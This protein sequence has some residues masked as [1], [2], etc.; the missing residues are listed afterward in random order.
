[1][2]VVKSLVHELARRF[3]GPNS[4]SFTVAWKVVRH[5]RQLL[6]LAPDAAPPD[7]FRIYLADVER[8][9]LELE[10]LL[11]ERAFARSSFFAKLH[12]QSA[13]GGRSVES[14]LSTT[15]RDLAELYIGLVVSGLPFSTG[16]E[17]AMLEEMRRALRDAVSDVVDPLLLDLSDPAVPRGTFVALD[18]CCPNSDRLFERYMTHATL[19]FA[20][21]PCEPFTR[22]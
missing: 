20:S 19:A 2:R 6:D 18:A 4:G 21:Y 8:D 16:D 7:Y 12:A 13:L 3:P 22:R 14:M 9:R 11:A 17:A 15:V 1:M 10:R 5:G